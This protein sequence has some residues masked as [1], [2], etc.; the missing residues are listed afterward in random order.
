MKGPFRI[1]EV[2]KGHGWD[3]TPS[4]PNFYPTIGARPLGNPMTGWPYE[5]GVVMH[6]DF[7]LCNRRGLPG[8]FDHGIQRL[9]LTANLLSNWMGDD[10]FIRRV[11]AQ[12]RKPCY[13]GDTQWYSGSVVKKYK[14]TLGGVD[15]GAVD[16]VL[17]VVNQVGENTLP[18]KATV[19]L[20]SKELGEVTLPIPLPSQEEW[21]HVTKRDVKDWLQEMSSGDILFP[22]LPSMVR[23]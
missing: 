10:G 8:P 3:H 5:S 21:T 7:N 17:T 9:T 15:Y 23:R 6:W 20:P 1:Q 19:Y 16:L 13:C 4:R 11:D 22:P 18:C 14:D 2:T 12:V